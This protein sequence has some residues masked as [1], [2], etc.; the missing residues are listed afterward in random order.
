MFRIFFQ[1]IYDSSLGSRDSL[2]TNF[3]DEDEELYILVVGLALPR[4]T[5][6]LVNNKVYVQL[7]L[8]V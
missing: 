8:V 4:C 3:C 1:R 6:L 2:H 5:R 7:V